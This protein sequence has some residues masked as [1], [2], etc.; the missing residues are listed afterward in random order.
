MNLNEGEEIFY[1]TGQIIFEQGEPSHGVYIILEGRIDLWHLDELGKSSRIASL[2]DGELMG[3]T[4]VIDNVNR[5][6]TAKV[7]K[8]T[9]VIF[10]KADTFRKSL[11]DPLVR[12]VVHTLS[13]RLKSF[14]SETPKGSPLE[15][16]STEAP[17]NCVTITSSS[18]EM[19]P[20]FNLPIK[21]EDFPFKIGNLG[22]GFEEA[23]QS[24]SGYFLPLP[25]LSSFADQHFEIVKR[26]GEIF[27]RDLGSQIGIFVHS[28]KYSRYSDDAVVALRPGQSLISIVTQEGK[29]LE[30]TV[31][32]PWTK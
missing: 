4:S 14:Y 3:E 5:S 1:R 8:P 27:V 30:F 17:L 25:E 6:V 28:H 29:T 10:I 32:V 12:F 26:S 9:K 21:V 19:A 11:S 13:A 18:P 31:S 24:K 22:A 16:A 23:R 15:D 7:A 2:I 20:Y